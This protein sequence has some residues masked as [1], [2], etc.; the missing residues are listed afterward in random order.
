VNEVERIMALAEAG[1]VIRMLRDGG[2][3][4]DEIA[5]KFKKRANPLG[6]S[7]KQL[8]RIYEGPKRYSFDALKRLAKLYPKAKR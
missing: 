7:P 5:T 2:T 8:Y 1:P 4:W 6:L 3:T